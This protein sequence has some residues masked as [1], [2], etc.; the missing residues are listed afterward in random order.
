MKRC[1]AILAGG[2]LAA[3]SSGSSGPGTVNSPALTNF[4]YSNPQPATTTQQTTANDASTS[5]S[6]VIVSASSGDAAS[7]SSAPELAD[8]IGSEALGAAAIAAPRTPTSDAAK[9][10]AVRTRSHQLDENCITT[11]ATTVTYN[12][13]SYSASG[14]TI[15][16]NGSLTATASSVTWNLTFTVSV[17]S[18]TE[19][20]NWI[21]DW[22]GDITYSGSS[23]SGTWT[24][25]GS[26]L[27]QNSGNYTANGQSESFGW[28]VGLNFLNLTA[29]SSCDS[30][31]GLVSGTL[32]VRANE[33][34]AFNIYGYTSEGIEY[35]WTACDTVEVATSAS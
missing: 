21:G 32:E 1:F 33:S 5:V 19:T 29:S 20:V 11:T 31:G 2:L 26:C 34:G 23:T 27:S 24:L 14:E 15:T 9:E 10:L 3:C 12:N 8:T 16:A 22:T 6:Q 7:A 28:T 4:T 35:T 13:C 25:N 17:T 30:G 18:S